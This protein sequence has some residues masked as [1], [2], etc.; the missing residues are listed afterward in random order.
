[1]NNY[2]YGTC[3]NVYG[4][5]YV[6]MSRVSVREELYSWYM[7]VCLRESVRVYEKCRFMR[8]ILSM[9]RERE[10]ECVCVCV[11]VCLCL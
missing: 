4:K 11:C 5:E 2:I 1:V 8:I 9:G 6:F 7:C 10:R 3:F